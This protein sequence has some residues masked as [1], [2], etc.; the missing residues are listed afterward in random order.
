MD[1][2]SIFK[3]VFGEQKPAYAWQSRFA[4]DEWPDV[5]IAPTG[6]GKTAGVTLGWVSHR[7]RDPENTPRRLVWCLPMRTL[8]DQTKREA[9]EWF[10]RLKEASIDKNHLLPQP[11]DVHVLMGGVEGARWLDNP[12]AACCDRWNA[13]HASQPRAHARVRIFAG[14]LADGIRASS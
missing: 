3:L 4:A 2:T 13:G 10:G 11:E 8:V 5:L 7:M 12:E 1:G 9:E 6:S 14:D